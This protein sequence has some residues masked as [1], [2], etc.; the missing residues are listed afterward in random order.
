MSESSRM[1]TAPAAL[2]AAISAGPAQ[3]RPQP[4]RAALTLA[5]REIVRFFR[6]RNRIVGSVGTPLLFW[7][8]FGA[9]LD[10]WFRVPGGTRES[11]FLEYFFP[12]SLVLTLMFTAIFSSI[13]V[14]EDRR[15]GFLQSVLVAPIP[16]WAMVLGKLLGGTFVAVLQGLIFLLLALTLP[17]E[18]GLVNLAQLAGLIFV[19]AL[20]LCGLGLALAWK[21]DSTQ[22]FHAVMNLVLMPLWLL[23]GG[24]FP[25]PL[26]GP[27]ATWAELLLHW[28][29]RLNPLSYAVAG[30]RQLLT[31][32]QAAPGVW[33]PALAEC[34]LVTVAF[35]VVA[36][37]AAT[38]VCRQ[39]TTGDLL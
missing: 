28:G 16:R 3:L 4:V 38:W 24:F 39:R 33:T 8:L 29:M 18:P 34:W 22:G 19:A 36:F 2:A 23:S 26:P 37:A 15:E 31:G 30:V 20:A 6:Q 13:S 12:G 21:M 27:S 14:I 7:L 17:W 10:K 32:P 9:G 25:V 11:G 35:A 5:W 1:A